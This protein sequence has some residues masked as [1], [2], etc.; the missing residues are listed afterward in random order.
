MD[1]YIFG[2][3]EQHTKGFGSRMMNRMGYR[4]G[5]GLGKEKQG[6][7]RPVPIRVLPERCALDH[8]KADGDAGRSRKQNTANKSKKS[9]PGE[10][11]S[12]R[13]TSGGG[14]FNFLNTTMNTSMNKGKATAAAGGVDGGG[15][16]ARSSLLA[17][18]RIRPVLD[19]VSSSFSSS[20]S[21][22]GGAVA[23]GTHPLRKSGVFADKKKSGGGSAV[24]FASAMSQSELRS[25]LVGAREAEVTLAAKIDRLQETIARNSERDPRTA[26]QARQ[27]LDE[28]R[29]Q[30]KEVRASRDRAETTL[31]NRDLGGGSGGGGGGGKGSK[32]SRKKGGMFSF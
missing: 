22:V 18:R 28:V 23:A 8:L 6:I 1:A 20:S 13:R 9:K 16:S 7:S 11:A 19:A 17:G 30:V 12:N 4:R 26:A 32:S 25:H 31:Q 2:D 14:V 15:P 29:M 24:A 21:A 27:K 5:E 10:Q 3:W